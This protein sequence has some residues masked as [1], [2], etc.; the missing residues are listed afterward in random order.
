[1]PTSQ[2]AGAFPTEYLE[3][4]EKVLRK[5]GFHQGEDQETIHT[6]PEHVL[7]GGEKR[8]ASSLPEI[9]CNICYEQTKLYSSLGCGHRFCNECY[10]TFMRLKIQDEGHA[11]I[12]ATCPDEKVR[13]LSHRIFLSGSQADLSQSPFVESAPLCPPSVSAWSE[14]EPKYRSSDEPSLSSAARRLVV[15]VLSRRHGALRPLAL[16]ERGAAQAVPERAP[17]RAL[18]RGRQS[19]PQ[20]VPRA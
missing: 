12:F 17:D 5:A 18:L 20:V 13:R 6:S 19:L 3:D 9:K 8:L 1:M 11:C 10:S 14:W 4:P 16:A 15:A 2:V 7:V